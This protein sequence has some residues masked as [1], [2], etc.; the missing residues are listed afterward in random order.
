[1]EGSMQS[2]DRDAIASALIEK[3]LDKTMNASDLELAAQYVAEMGFTGMND[4]ELFLS[5]LASAPA[6]AGHHLAV[7]GGLFMHS[8]NVTR[9][10]LEQTELL[11]VRWPY[12]RSPY[13]VGMCHDLCKFDAYEE[14]PE[15]TNSFRKATP[16][17]P[18]H[19]L[20]SAAMLSVLTGLFD[21]GQ[22]V[23]EAEHAAIVFHMGAWGIGKDYSIDEL[24]GAIKRHPLE[25]IATHTADM[26]ALQYDETL[27]TTGVGA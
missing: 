26:V 9:R 18:G 4:V 14:V 7:R 11:H 25:V 13:L 27:P 12:R 8:F 1:M 19:G 24:D 2:P 10:L 3:G 21:H 22:P 23:M 16:F 20:K 6:S 15:Y 17:L 5:F